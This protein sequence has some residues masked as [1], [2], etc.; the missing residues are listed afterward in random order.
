V[1]S[2]PEAKPLLIASMQGIHCTS[3]AVYVFPRLGLR[4][5]EQGAYVWR[6]LLDSG[7]LVTN[8]TD[9]PVEDVNPIE[10]F[11]A[12]VTRKLA[13]GATFFPK[14]CMTREEA[15]R[16]YTRDGAYAAFEEGIKGT[17]TPG[18]LADIVILSKDIMTCPDDEIRKAKVEFTIVGGRVRYE[19]K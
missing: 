10:S 2:L 17:L 14:Q 16:S 5:A 19:A 11:H 8:G 15:L 12:S 6:S 3:D 18:K 1:I 4:R 13:S 7:A 9:A